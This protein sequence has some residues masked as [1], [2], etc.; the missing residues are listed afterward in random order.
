MMY[1]YIGNI[2]H[3]AIMLKRMELSGIDD[4]ASVVTT[5]SSHWWRLQYQWYTALGWWVRKKLD[6]GVTTPQ[7]LFGVRARSVQAHCVHTCVAYSNHLN[8]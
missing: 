8:S 6:E 2:F 3:N 4:L 1:T 5:Y 7:G